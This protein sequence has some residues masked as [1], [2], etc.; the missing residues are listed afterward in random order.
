MASKCE[1]ITLYTVDKRC[2]ILREDWEN[3]AKTI[4][5]EYNQFGKRVDQYWTSAGGRLGL[6]HRDNLSPTRVEAIEKR[7]AIYRELFPSLYQDAA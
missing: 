1:F 3:P 7:E 6:V 4:L 5:V 2:R